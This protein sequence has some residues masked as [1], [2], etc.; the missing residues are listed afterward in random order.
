M[1]PIAL[2]LTGL[3]AAPAAASAAPT[4]TTDQPCYVADE[5]SM[6]FSGSGYSPNGQVGLFFSAGGKYGSYMATADASGAFTASVRAPSFEAFGEDPPSY[7]MSV[8]AN[9]EAKIGP[10]GPLAPP[11]EI[12]A[13]MDLRITEWSADVPAF[14]KPVRRGQRVKLTTYGWVGAG[15]TLYVHYLRG[16]KAVHSEKL[17]ALKGPCGDLI[18]NFKAFNF[19]TAKPGNYAVRFSASA[20]WSGKDRWTGYKRV[21][22]AS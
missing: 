14:E 6:E 1:R 16:G 17:A 9:D 13:F 19:K 15:E 7:P 10:D 2:A 4:V 8:T 12:V 20:Q 5:Q 22:L 21:K 18:K 3:L 11:E